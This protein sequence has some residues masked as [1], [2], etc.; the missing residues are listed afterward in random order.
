[1]DGSS[2]ARHTPQKL[3]NQSVAPKF[4]ILKNILEN[5]LEEGFTIK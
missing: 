2:Y 1:M 5:V 4:N 3:T